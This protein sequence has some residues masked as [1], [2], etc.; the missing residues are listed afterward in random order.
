MYALLYKW[1]IRGLVPLLRS[2]LAVST[3]TDIGKSS[4]KSSN[5]TFPRLLTHGLQI[6]HTLRKSRASDPQCCPWEGLKQFNPLRG[7]QPRG[8][9][10]TF[11]E[12]GDHPVTPCSCVRRAR[13]HTPI[14]S[15]FSQTYETTRAC[16][17]LSLKGW[18]CKQQSRNIK[19]QRGK[20][21]QRQR[22]W[23]W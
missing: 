7:W 15:V 9:C 5:S 10:S 20:E 12:A 18:P 16:V 11:W 19:R 13:G 3:S 23:K 17:S 6:T 21:T 2:T 1:Q 4:Q 22:G 14:L 8:S